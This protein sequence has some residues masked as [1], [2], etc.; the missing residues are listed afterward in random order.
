MQNKVP[1]ILHSEYHGC[2]WLG[3]RKDQGI[4]N[5]GIDHDLF[6]FPRVK[7]SD[8]TNNL[9]SLGSNHLEKIFI[10]SF[11]R[12]NQN[13]NSRCSFWWKFRQHDDVSVSVHVLMGE[14]ALAEESHVLLLYCRLTSSTA[15]RDGVSVER[16]VPSM[17]RL[18]LVIEDEPTDTYINM[19]V[20]TFQWRR[21]EHDGVSNHQPHDCLPNRLFKA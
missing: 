10:T 4:S 9:E 18:E 1:F 6:Q 13:E 20:R 19:T 7:I 16:N 21:D 5:S 17:N 2:W 12:S 3:L 14:C 15:W 8:V 11:T